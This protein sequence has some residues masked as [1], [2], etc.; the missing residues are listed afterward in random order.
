MRLRLR[1]KFGYSKEPSLVL[2]SGWWGEI[3]RASVCHL[4][5]KSCHRPGECQVVEFKWAQEKQSPRCQHRS[6]S[7]KINEFRPPTLFPT[8]GFRQRFRQ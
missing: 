5:E 8:V 6:F 3:L 4:L 2:R 1:S 7:N